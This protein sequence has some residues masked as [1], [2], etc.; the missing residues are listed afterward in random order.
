MAL[1]EVV[2]SMVKAALM[3]SIQ[4]TLP[5]GPCVQVDEELADDT[6]W[7]FRT[8]ENATPHFELEGECTHLLVGTPKW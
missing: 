5:Q 2:H 6:P 8:W 7:H 3:S 1:V 4:K